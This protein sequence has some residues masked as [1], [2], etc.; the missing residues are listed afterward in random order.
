MIDTIKNAF[1]KGDL[2]ALRAKLLHSTSWSQHNTKA[3]GEDKLQG[4][5]LN[6]LKL[7]G[8]CEVKNTLSISQGEQQVISLA[9]QPENSNSSI[10]YTL[11]LETNGN[12]IKSV[13]AI[14]DTVQLSLATDKASEQVIQSLPKPD[15][16]VLQD[17]DQ[18]DH[19]QSEL[20]VPSN[21]AKLSAEHKTVLDAWWSI[22]SKAQLAAIADVYQDSASISL[23][24]SLN[25]AT[26]ADLFNYALAKFS[27]VTRAFAQLEQVVVEGE[28][29]AVKWYLDGDENGQRIRAPFIT[30][31]TI[32]NGKITAEQT[33]CDIFAFINRFNQS[34]LFNG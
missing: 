4:V 14:V 8:Q 23:P 27:K 2:A 21:V 28:Q 5:V 13:N 6:W 12:V 11:W 15:A 1:T 22:W 18:Q 20:A 30:L 24:G 19:L 26:P 25:S 9:L 29:V 33:N 3:F 34:E 16:F 7:A 32:E 31:L 10:A 17:Y